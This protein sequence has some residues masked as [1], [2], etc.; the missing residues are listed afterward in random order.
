MGQAGQQN[1]ATFT[2]RYWKKVF[3]RIIMQGDNPCIALY[4]NKEA[5]ETFQEVPLQYSY[6]LSDI[7]HQVGT[8]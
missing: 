8:K 1:N 7:S 6:S 5:K 3:V 2:F 4:E